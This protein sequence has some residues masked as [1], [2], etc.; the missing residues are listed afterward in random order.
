[1]KIQCCFCKHICSNHDYDEM[2]D[3]EIALEQTGIPKCN[4]SQVKPFHLFELETDENICSS[5]LKAFN[6]EQNL[7]EKISSDSSYDIYDVP[8]ENF[9]SSAKEEW[10]DRPR[11]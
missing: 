9:M 10:D 4:Q 5:Y 7:F 3:C 11:T 6:E 1:M 8:F 2:L